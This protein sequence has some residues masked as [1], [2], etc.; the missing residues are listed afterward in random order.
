MFRLL[1]TNVIPTASSVSSSSSPLSQ[2]HLAVYSYPASS[3]LSFSPCCL[4]LSSRLRVNP[5]PSSSNLLNPLSFLFSFSP[6]LRIQHDVHP[7][8]SSSFLPPHHDHPNTSEIED[9]RRRSNVP[10]SNKR[11][12]FTASI[13]PSSLFSSSS[14]PL[15]LLHASHVEDSQEKVSS[16]EMT[17]SH[18]SL[19]WSSSYIKPG[20][21]ETLRGDVNIRGGRRRDKEEREEEQD[22]EEEDG[23]QRDVLSS[24]LSRS[25]CPSPTSSA[26]PSASIPFQHIE[27]EEE[28]E[29]R[30]FVSSRDV[31]G[32]DEGF[33]PYLA[34]PYIH[35]FEPRRHLYHLG[36]NSKPSWMSPEHCHYS[37]I[38]FGK[39]IAAH[40]V[41]VAQT[42]HKLPNNPWPQV[43]VVGHSNVGKSSLLNA[44]MHGRDVARSC[45]KPLPNGKVL[46]L[47]KVAPVSHTPGRTRHLFIFDLGNHMSLVD[48][49]GYGFARVTQRMKE[50]WALLI[51]DYF[52]QS[53][54]LKRVLS[55]ID[56]TKGV[57]DLDEKL[58][59]LL[60]EKNLPFQVILTKVDLLN[61]EQLHDAVFRLLLKLQ[62]AEPT[63]ADRGSSSGVLR[64]PRHLLHPYIHAVSARRHFGIRE[65][66]ASLAAIASDA[67]QRQNLPLIKPGKWG[68]TPV[69]RTR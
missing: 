50:E 31:V 68:N 15:S 28:K 54:Q 53:R 29:E 41:L 63:P 52:T 13:S 14:F 19:R 37:R 45:S 58:W 49:P 27:R 65:L 1:T 16:H 48:L 61:T 8:L 43:A 36:E 66:R 55:L 7:I 9:R 42:I 33:A 21:T 64:L 40:P 6:S 23:Q 62:S 17:R 56:A 57:R 67:R 44:L 26:S 35:A 60:I 30:C 10:L 39:P 4:S 20:A 51:E 32:G 2:P 3:S 59:Q 34:Q 46:T 11:F 18:S 25:S 38:L 69:R 24:S 5:F 22:A 47:P 12:L